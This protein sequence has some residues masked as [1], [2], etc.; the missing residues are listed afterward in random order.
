VELTTLAMKMEAGEERC[1]EEG[2]AVLP[3]DARPQ[4]SAAEETRSD[5]TTAL[6][7]VTLTQEIRR[8]G[9]L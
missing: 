6:L 7:P 3:P 5:P 9:Y 4:P 1:H 8:K 2:V